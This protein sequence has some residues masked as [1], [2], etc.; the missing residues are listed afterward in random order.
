LA[1]ARDRRRK[2]A[3]IDNDIGTGMAGKPGF[4]KP[5]Q[6]VVGVKQ[7]SGNIVACRLFIP[8]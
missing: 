3:D 7:Q 8:I 5:W 4:D 1:T 2:R 6:L